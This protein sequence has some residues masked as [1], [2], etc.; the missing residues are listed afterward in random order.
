MGNDYING[1]YT[2]SSRSYILK[3]MSKLE[4]QILEHQNKHGDIG[5]MEELNRLYRELGQTFMN[6]K[7]REDEFYSDITETCYVEP[8]FTLE[9]F[10]KV[11]NTKPHENDFEAWWT[12]NRQEIYKILKTN[13]EKGMRYILFSYNQPM[14]KDL[15]L[16]GD[17]AM[18]KFGG[19]ICDKFKDMG[20]IYWKYSAEVDWC[21]SFEYKER[22][23]YDINPKLLWR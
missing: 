2:T 6:L 23:S 8:L 4:K 1:G 15:D 10:D 17:E 11:F 12:I 16:T 22:L 18:D 13:S 3:Q 5:F 20:A 19:F 7:N 14:C 21:V 9:E